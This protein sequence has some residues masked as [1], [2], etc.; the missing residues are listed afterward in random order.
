MTIKELADLLRTLTP[1]NT[2]ALNNEAL[3]ELFPSVGP[4]I[5]DD[6]A[7]SRVKHFAKTCGCVFDFHEGTRT[8]TF[9]K[10]TGASR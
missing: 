1:E 2:F 4:F 3:E 9:T 7:R 10:A 6:E 8:G 5:F